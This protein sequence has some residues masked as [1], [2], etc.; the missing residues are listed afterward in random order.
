MLFVW[1]VLMGSCT[2]LYGGDFLPETEERRQRELLYKSER[3]KQRQQFEAAERK[4]K[5]ERKQQK[6][7]R[8]YSY[9]HIRWLLGTRPKKQ[10]HTLISQVSDGERKH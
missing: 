8:S 5:E 6:E 1:L 10:P 7:L 9:V 3:K 4:E 2:H